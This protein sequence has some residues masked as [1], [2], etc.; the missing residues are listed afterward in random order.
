MTPSGI[1][2]SSP[3]LRPLDNELDY[4]EKAGRTK[5][6]PRPRIPR[7]C[8]PARV[9]VGATTTPGSTH[10]HHIEPTRGLQRSGFARRQIGRDARRENI[11]GSCGSDAGK[12]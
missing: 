9:A 4:H 5:R 12:A 7:R 11:N 2:P 6:L 8:A 10:L 1:S 3:A